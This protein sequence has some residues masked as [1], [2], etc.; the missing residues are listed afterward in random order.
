M[1]IQWSEDYATG[2]REVDEQH[3]CLFDMLNSFEQRLQRKEP[4]AKMMDVLD[5]LA[6]YA[7]KHF[8]CEE[9]CMERCACPAASVDKLAHQRFVRMVS[10]RIQDF[11]ARPPSADAFESLHNEIVDWIKSHICKIDVRLRQCSTPL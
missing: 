1:S 7:V 6:D 8:S 5:G 4:P 10:S 3:R 11:K 9:G 2:V